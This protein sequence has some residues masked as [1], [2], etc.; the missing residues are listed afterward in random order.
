MVSA[1][2]AAQR[3]RQVALFRHSYF[4]IVCLFGRGNTDFRITGHRWPVVRILLAAALWLFTITGASAQV[5]P[6]NPPCNNVDVT[7]TIVTCAGDV[8]QGIVAIGPAY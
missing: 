4:C 8:H 7:G 5:T 1:A 6:P 2:T 3:G